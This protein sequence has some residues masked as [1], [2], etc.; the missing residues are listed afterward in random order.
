MKKK[1]CKQEIR[2]ICKIMDIFE[3]VNEVKVL[4][5]KLIIQTLELV[6]EDVTLKVNMEK[7]MNEGILMMAKTR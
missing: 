2:K 3:N 7:L 6:E 4:L 5:D 1:I